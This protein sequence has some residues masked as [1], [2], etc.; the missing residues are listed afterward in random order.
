[1]VHQMSQI[2]RHSTIKT[3]EGWYHKKKVLRREIQNKNKKILKK[4][5]IFCQKNSTV[6]EG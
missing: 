2:S 3:E 5:L 1:M 4:P 6:E